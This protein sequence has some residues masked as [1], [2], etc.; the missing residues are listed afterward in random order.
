MIIK[1]EKQLKELKNYQPKSCLVSS[2]YLNTD[3]SKFSK[4]EIEVIFKDLVKEKKIEV[5][6]D[7]LNDIKK[8]E[9][10]IS[11]NLDIVKTKGIV[12]FSCSKEDFW[13][14]YEL[15]VSP[16]NLFVIDKTPYIR[17]LLVITSKLRKIC[18]TI[19]DHR[20][21]KIYEIFGNEI[22]LKEEIYDETP[23]RIKVAGYHG[24]D[25]SRVTEY[26]ENKIIEHFKKIGDRLLEIYQNEK[27]ESLFIGAKQQDVNLFVERLHPYLKKIYGGSFNLPI[28]AKESDVLRKTLELEMKLEI[29][30]EKNI[31]DQIKT[32]AHSKTSGMA[33]I[34]IKDTIRALNESNVN[35]LVFNLNFSYS[36]KYC[37]SCN[38]LAL[39]EDKCPNCGVNFVRVPNIIFKVIDVA[40]EKNAEIYPIFYSDDL[41]Q[42][43]IGAILRHKGIMKT[44]I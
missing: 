43:G 26:Q 39:K 24:F 33:V 31:I 25:E 11:Q 13:Q 27:F 42:E 9:Q 22:I 19:F 17:P 37:P 3:G 44:T 41:N 34:G 16:P 32:H 21:A 15:S 38:Y 36:G 35:K 5:T 30:R 23:K 6:E 1:S 10:Y 18:T 20:K 12:I 28:D 8:M 14:V 7:V 29:E 2:L 40:V 4:K